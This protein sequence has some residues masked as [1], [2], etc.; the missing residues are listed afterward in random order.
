[1]TFSAASRIR[2]N[3]SKFRFDPSKP[4]WIENAKLLAR[5]AGLFSDI[6]LTL[7]SMV[8]IRCCSR[9]EASPLPASAHRLHQTRSHERSCRRAG[10]ALLA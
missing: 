6:A 5:V 8:F 9:A 7:V 2:W 3:G 1:M 10:M 4:R